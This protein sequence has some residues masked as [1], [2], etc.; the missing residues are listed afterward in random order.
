VS[1]VHPSLGKMYE[2]EETGTH[3]TLFPSRFPSQCSECGEP[4]AER[5][6]VLGVPPQMG[7][8]KLVEQWIVFC[9][10][11]AEQT[12]FTLK[13]TVKEP[14]AKDVIR[15]T[16]NSLVDARAKFDPEQLAAVDAMSK[17][18]NKKQMQ[19]WKYVKLLKAERAR[20]RELLARASS[21][22]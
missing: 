22:T 4:I 3:A 13:R 8:Y 5:D 18:S 10:S 12:S 17:L 7:K 6:W 21:G 2:S 19:V 9:L 15:Q 20:M 16:R 11:C 1:A 14:T